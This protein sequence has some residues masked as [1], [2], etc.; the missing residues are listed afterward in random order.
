MFYDYLMAFTRRSNIF[1]PEMEGPFKISRS[2]LDLFF[3]CPRCFYMDRRLGVGRPS[4]PGFTLNNA[5]D[6]LLKKEFDIHRVRG[7]QHPL[8]KAY[9]I[10]AVPFMH[11]MINEWRENFKGVQYYHAL[12]NFIVTGAVDD[13]WVIPNGELIVVDY[14]ATSMDGEIDMDSK[15]KQGYKR[16][17]EIYQWLMR[18]NNFKVL[19]TGYFVYAN[20]DKD[21]TA[22]DGKLEFKVQIIPYKGD[23]SWVEPHI[24]HAK[25]CLM[26]EMPASS[27]ECEYCYYRERAKRFE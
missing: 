25:K 17:I 10:E 3:E 26:G 9:G 24:I 19:D 7:T 18:R 16:Q 12:T 1:D 27:N 6:H 4:M 13:L 8:M 22:F 23:D 5:V 2:K 21:K 20:G 14:K 11:E 15:Y